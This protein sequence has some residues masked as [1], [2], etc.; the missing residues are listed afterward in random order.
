MNP[1]AKS[2]F[3]KA[4]ETLGLDAETRDRA[5]RRIADLQLSPDDP[6][7]VFLALAG[8]LEKAA[9]EVPRAIETLPERVEDAA[10][11]AVKDISKTATGAANASLA[12]SAERVVEG[13]KADIQSAAILALRGVA[14]RQ[15]LIAPLLV[16]LLAAA[17]G[18]VALGT[19]YG[20]G[21]A[22]GA[23]IDRRWQALSM[24][25][26][27]TE[28]QGLI[29][30]NADLSKTLK[31]NCAAGGKAAYLVRGE[32]ACTIPLWLDGAPGPG[33]GVTAIGWG[34]AMRIAADWSFALGISGGVL[35][36]LILRKLLIA[37]GARSSVR[38]LLDLRL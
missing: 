10:R 30:A 15:R 18:V 19:G 36:G 21:R 4:A 1:E 35:L 16:T 2:R 26:D 5:W 17:V 28:W 14:A 31:E 23:A 27:A 11:R 12:S 29:A 7:V 3:D 25:A 8:V 22:E 13:A 24:R 38:W 20:L 37:L 33:A 32:R 6:T 9:I 34:G